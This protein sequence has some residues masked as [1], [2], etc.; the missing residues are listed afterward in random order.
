MPSLLREP[1]AWLAAGLLF[2]HAGA[3]ASPGD[4]GPDAVPASALASPT[5]LGAE[6]FSASPCATIVGGM[7][8]FVLQPHGP[9]LEDIE[10][11]ELRV[12]SLDLLEIRAV[13]MEVVRRLRAQGAAGT[14]GRAAASSLV[15][16]GSALAGV[17][18]RPVESVIGLPAGM[19]RVFGRRASR[20]GRQASDLGERAVE[21]VSDEAL[22]DAS[23]RPRDAEPLPPEPE[24]WWQKGGGVA[25]KLGKRW[26]GYNAARRELGR[27]LGIDPYSTNPWLGAEMDRLAWSALV[28]RRG[29]GFGLGQVGGA[30]G[31]VLGE[32]GRIHRMVWEKPPEE[33]EAWN[34]AR[35]APLACHTDVQDA[36]FDN[37]RYSPTLQTQAVDALLEL[38]PQGG[39]EFFLGLAASVQREAEARFVV[40]AL[41]LM[42]AAR[43]RFPTRF[44][45][46]GEA[47]VLRD[48]EERL[49]LALPVDL[50]QWTPET[51]DFF[52]D[53]ALARVADKRLLLSRDASPRARAALLAE[54][55]AV[56]EQSIGPAR[57]F[58]VRHPHIDAGY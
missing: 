49:W 26:L 2:V 24:P 27:E 46:F 15:Q 36:F 39:C 13:E 51:A 19:L 8:Q 29:V 10:P 48:G 37:S 1:R 18:T 4:C 41:Q 16:T 23:L 20:Y 22:F 52:A 14:A 11:A 32:S 40:D 17:V 44:E 12:E 9:G 55:W 57:E 21:A 31:T 38:A 5:L 47:L 25:L 53:P 58:S 3:H 30:A 42:V 43:P 54:G 28:G 56:V 34:V 45:I 7:A 50:L 33:V 6:D 35:L